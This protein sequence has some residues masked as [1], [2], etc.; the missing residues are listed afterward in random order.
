MVM[1]NVLKLFFT[2]MPMHFVGRLYDELAT[3]YNVS[4]VGQNLFI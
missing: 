4:S 3:C 1:M 2:E